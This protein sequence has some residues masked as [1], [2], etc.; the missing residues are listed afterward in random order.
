MLLI[1]SRFSALVPR[2]SSQLAIRGVP[3]GV[4]GLGSVR[5]LSVLGKSCGGAVIAS[6]LKPPAFYLL[7][8]RKERKNTRYKDKTYIMGCILFFILFL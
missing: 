5:F 7:K 8:R 3:E 6:A 2:E 4:V 1:L